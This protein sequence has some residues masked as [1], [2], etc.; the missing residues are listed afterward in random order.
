MSG[1]S[2]WNEND[3]ADI[4]P[5][6]S[7]TRRQVLTMIGALMGMSWAKAALAQR[8][9]A[10]PG[11]PKGSPQPVGNPAV[12]PK[13]SPINPIIPNNQPKL[14][15]DTTTWTER[16][17][18]IRAA[19]TEA[20]HLWQWQ[21]NFSD[22]TIY[23][24]NAT[25]GRLNGPDLSALIMSK[26][27]D[28]LNYTIAKAFADAVGEAWTAWAATVRFPGL[29][30]YP[31]FAAFPAPMAPPMPNIPIPL[32]ALY[33]DGTRMMPASL[34]QAIRS[35]LGAIADEPGAMDAIQFFTADLGARFGFWLPDCM[36]TNVMGQG[37]IPTFAPPYVPVGPVVGGTIIASPGHL[38]V[39]PFPN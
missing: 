20:I 22:V 38:A 5:T 4:A 36:V 31:A 17:D 1:N 35:K 16:R 15:P 26:R 12:A 19:V 8:S 33:Q 9:I 28:R 10:M 34:T 11:L 21:A 39:N 6:K 18:M 2:E 29:P 7:M 13:I 24:V 14:L 3:T 25:G 27:P 30:L 23:A 32:L 37:P